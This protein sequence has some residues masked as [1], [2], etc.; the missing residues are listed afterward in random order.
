MDQSWA[1]A[2]IQTRRRNTSSQIDI[3]PYQNWKA[4]S[5][6]ILG[7]LDPAPSWWEARCLEAAS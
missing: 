1:L 2:N 4:S 5:W 3:Q 7:P 6:T